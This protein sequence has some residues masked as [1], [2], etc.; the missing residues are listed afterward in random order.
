MKKTISTFLFLQF[1][2]IMTFAQWVSSES[3]TNQDFWAISIGTDQVAY[4]GGGPWQ[5]TS[6]CVI[7]KT[8]D[9]GQTWEAQNPASFNSC[10]FGVNALNADTV[11][12]VGCNATYYY[13]LILRSFDGGQNWT[14]KNISNTY[15]FYCVEFPSETIGYTCGWNGR[16][17]KTED[18]GENWNSLASGSSQVFRRMCFVDENL[19][20]AACGT[21]HASTNKIYKTIDGNSWSLIKNFGSNF[22]IGGIH[23]FDENTGVVV[24][25]NGSKA[26]IKRTTDAGENWEDVLEGNYSF[27]LECLSFDGGIGWAAGKYGSN[28]GIFRTE[29]GGQTWELH[30]SGL[31]GTPYSI[32][33][34]DTTSFI[35]GTSGMIMKFTESPIVDVDP[36]KVK[37]SMIYPNPANKSIFLDLISFPNAG[38]YDI[39]NYRGTLVRSGVVP[40]QQKINIEVGDW[41]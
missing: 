23:F 4:A 9:G 35:A 41:S 34:K 40:S 32:L 10:I 24:G 33:K 2:G 27:V 31:T 39:K 22:I 11:Y 5:F 37:G 28:N 12:A 17:Y 7:S 19:G 21:D 14:T 15:G 16:I 6:S 36:Q 29:D 13:G 20:F 30:F 1:V 18:A 8:V 38:S 26:V 25:T 3:G